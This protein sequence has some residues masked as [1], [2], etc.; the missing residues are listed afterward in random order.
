MYLLV[1]FLTRTSTCILHMYTPFFITRFQLISLSFYSVLLK[2]VILKH[3]VVKD[4]EHPNM[5]KSTHCFANAIFLTR[6]LFSI[7]LEFSDNN[8]YTFSMQLIQNVN[9]EGTHL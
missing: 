6:N 4:Q 3:T 7:I 5:Q 8:K 2:C 9:L 1:I